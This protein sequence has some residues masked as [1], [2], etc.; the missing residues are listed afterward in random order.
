MGAFKIVINLDVTALLE[1]GHVFSARNGRKY[2]NLELTQRR[3]PDQY[4]QDICVSIER[5]REARL[6]GEARTFVGAGVS[7]VFEDN[8]LIEKGGKPIDNLEVKM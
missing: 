2:V 3:E 5:S 1:G 6:R 7:Y 4:G 8:K